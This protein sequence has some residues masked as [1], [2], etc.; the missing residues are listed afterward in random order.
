MYE[1]IKAQI[2]V[3]VEARQ[4]AA[5]IDEVVLAAYKK[6]ADSNDAIISSGAKAKEDLAE[7]ET[8][9]RA[10]TIAAFNTT[11]EKA[12]VPGVG[13]RVRDKLEYDEV[14]ALDWAKS[15][16][17]ALSL[18]KRAFEKICKA[19]KPDFVTVTQEPTATI[20]TELKAED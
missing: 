6:W 17:L 19:D 7:A 3:V 5:K 11:G 8:L 9:L 2:K 20:A 12:P 15:H 1:E 14:A 10:L 13:I 16:G 18:D 4:K